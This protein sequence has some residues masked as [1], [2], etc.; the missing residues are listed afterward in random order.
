VGR[1][2]LITIEGIDGAGKSTHARALAEA[3]GQRGRRVLA[4]FEPGATELGAALRRLLLAGDVPLSTDAELLLFLADR[5]DHVSRVIA[6][7]LA[8]GT[9]V[10]CDR[11]TD[12]TLA[13]QGYGRDGDLTRL[14]R[15]N[16]ECSG[17]LVPDL[18]LLLDCPIGEGARR[19]HRADDRYQRRDADY[20]ERVRQGFLALAAA[21][22]ERIRVIDA[23]APLAEVRARV[24]ELT[25]AWLAE[26]A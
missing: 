15:W 4:T 3:L 12:S 22:P 8:A 7:A 21:A 10:I 5:A 9:I 1:G 13:Y 18:T 17:G 24:A 14:A 25:V 26:R 11:F 19:R 16:A 23:T 2:H 20:H 6:P